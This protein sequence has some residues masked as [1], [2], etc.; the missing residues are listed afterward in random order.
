MGKETNESDVRG[1]TR[2]I[3]SRQR[4]KKGPSALYTT[5]VK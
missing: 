3:Q 5:Q 2:R 1:T 4:K